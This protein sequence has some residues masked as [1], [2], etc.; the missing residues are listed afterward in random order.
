MKEALLGVA[1]KLGAGKERK[2]TISIFGASL[3][4]D[5]GQA[6]FPEPQ[7]KKMR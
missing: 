5:R 1:C 4:C 6:K 3:K 7:E 2:K